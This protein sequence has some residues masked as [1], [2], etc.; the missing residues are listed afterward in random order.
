MSNVRVTNGKLPID[1]LPEVEFPC[2]AAI[3]IEGQAAASNQFPARPF[4]RKINCG[5]PA[6]KD[7]EADLPWR[8]AASRATCR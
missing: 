3:V 4:S 2:I 5:G 8:A 6:D 7:Y 1:F